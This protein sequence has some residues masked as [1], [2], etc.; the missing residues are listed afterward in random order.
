MTFFGPLCQVLNQSHGA[1]MFL[2]ER[3]LTLG[4]E[5]IMEAGGLQ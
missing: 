4:K 1:Y 2:W 5:H 3:R